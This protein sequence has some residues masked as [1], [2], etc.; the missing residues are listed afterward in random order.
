MVYTPFFIFTK[1]LYQKLGLSMNNSKLPGFL[2]GASG[3]AKISK[4]LK[5][6]KE[7]SGSFRVD[8]T[9]VSSG[10]KLRH[11]AENNVV[12]VRHGQQG[13]ILPVSLDLMKEYDPKSLFSEGRN[14][15]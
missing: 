13:K 7:F 14:L 4:R 8:G 2:T 15:S 3:A 1:S 9:G 6:G 11:V 12:Y 10:G 5:R